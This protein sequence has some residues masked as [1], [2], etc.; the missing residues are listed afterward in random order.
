LGG[1]AAAGAGFSSIIPLVF[2]AGGRIPQVS[3]GAGV[4]TVSGLGY[5][6]FLV[7]PPVIGLVSELT[8]L[9]VGLLLLVLLSVTA[10]GLV[11][12]VV[13]GAGGRSNPFADTAS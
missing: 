11:G 2:A 9:R 3:E 12:V 1:F 6:G 5:L 4:A 7:G 8:S 10:A 13:R